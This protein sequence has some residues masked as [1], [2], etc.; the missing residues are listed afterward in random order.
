MKRTMITGGAIGGALMYLFDPHLGRT[1]R[2]K[3][4][5]QLGGLLRQGEREAGRKTEYARGQAEGLRHLVSSESPPENDPALT[6]KVESEVLSR[7]K[8][9]K[10]QIS[11]NSTDG[12]VELRGV[13][14]TPDQISELEQEVRK[15][16]GVVDVHNYLHLP[17]TPAPN[18][19]DALDK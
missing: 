6:A 19:Q 7:W 11:I 12:I 10:G 17:N 9:P 16:T 3:L 8:Y 14:E 13:C 4:Q 5:D 18:K 1:R 2:A 15:V